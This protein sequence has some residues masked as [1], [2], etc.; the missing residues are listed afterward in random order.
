MST[1]EPLRTVESEE[2]EDY[3]YPG[4]LYSL[5]VIQGVKERSL[6]G[7]PTFYPIGDDIAANGEEEY[8]IPVDENRVW[9][10]DAF[11]SVDI[12]PDLFYITLTVGDQPILERQLLRMPIMDVQFLTPFPCTGG[13]YIKVENP[14]TTIQTYQ[15]VL[16]Y[17]EFVRTTFNRTL[18]FLGLE[19]I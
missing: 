19:K 3:V 9:I 18:D 14:L 7:Y 12:L 15:A 6:S 13:I 10:V 4:W 5:P 8:T 17:R 11:S 1:Q 2:D 16:R